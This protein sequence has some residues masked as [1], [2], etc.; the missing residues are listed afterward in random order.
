MPDR[1]LELEYEVRKD[2][3]GLY[4]RQDVG[5]SKGFLTFIG[6]SFYC[7]KNDLPTTINKILAGMK[8]PVISYTATELIPGETF[9][10]KLKP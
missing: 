9:E 2:I 4:L 1:I 5:A 7:E 3:L 6:A 8:Y 10:G